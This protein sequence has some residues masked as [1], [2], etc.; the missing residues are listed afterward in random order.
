MGAS[1]GD[2]AEPVINNLQAVGIR[3]KLRPFEWAAFYKEYGEKE[4]SRT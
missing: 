3:T 4:H 1:I 2:F